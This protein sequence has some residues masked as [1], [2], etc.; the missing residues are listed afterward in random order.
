MDVRVL[1]P[2]GYEREGTLHDGTVYLGDG[3]WR[4]ASVTFLP[5]ASPTKIVCLARNVAAH[6]AEHDAEVPSR[7]SY[8]LKPPSALAAHRGTVVIPPAIDGVEYEAELAAV[9]GRQLTGV[10]EADAV[11][12]LAGLTI[13]NDLSNR[14]DQRRELNWVRG[15]AFDGAAP[16]GPGLVD[17]EAVPEDARIEL[18]VN[19]EVRQRGSR[20]DY[21]FALPTV[22][23]DLT[24]YVTLEP[25][26][27]VAMGTPAGVGP[28]D[29]GDEVAITIEGIGTLEHGVR[30][31][32]AS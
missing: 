3:D 23:A 12:G 30:Y 28:L 24:R 19:G 17:P 13:M 27:V 8:F 21:A 6:A 29:D 14:A 2:A 25:G 32:D 11:A 16:L 1:D 20:A 5:P 26:D 9:V 18:R 4:P 10:D 22:L 31:F 7:P 15:K